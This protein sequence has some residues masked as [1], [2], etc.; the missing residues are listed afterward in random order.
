MELSKAILQGNI[1]FIPELHHYYYGY[2]TPLF[3]LIFNIFA[4]GQ[5]T[6]TPSEVIFSADCLSKGSFSYSP[7]FSSL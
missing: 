6:V 2:T 4:P 1:D 7:L 5:E 3:S